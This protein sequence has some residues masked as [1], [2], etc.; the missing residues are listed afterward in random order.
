MKSKDGC[1]GPFFLFFFFFYLFLFFFFSFFFLKKLI[2]VSLSFWSPY[3]LFPFGMG[4]MVVTGF[5]TL[6]VLK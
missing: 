2:N 5:L 3:R 4:N 6:L 1:F